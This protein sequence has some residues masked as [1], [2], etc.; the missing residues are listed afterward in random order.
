MNFKS[1]FDM[2]INVEENRMKMKGSIN[3]L[4]YNAKD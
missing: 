4:K 2:L 3:Q 1:K